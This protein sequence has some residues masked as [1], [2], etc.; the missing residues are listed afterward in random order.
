M[1]KLS[2]FDAATLTIF[3]QFLMEF[4]QHT[5]PFSHTIVY[6]QSVAPLAI[7]HLILIEFYYNYVYQL[8]RLAMDATPHS[9][10][11]FQFDYV[12]TRF[13][14]AEPQK[15]LDTVEDLIGDL[16]RF[17][18]IHIVDDMAWRVCTVLPTSLSCK[19]F[20]MVVPQLSMQFM[21][22]IPLNHG[23]GICKQRRSEDKMLRHVLTFM[24]RSGLTD[25]TKY[26]S[27][28]TLSWLFFDTQN[29][30]WGTAFGS[31]YNKYL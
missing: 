2:L 14:S 21:Y 22:D 27:N 29:N 18:T 6:T 31:P 30:I 10:Q 25:M 26:S 20:P 12:I 11:L 1:K 9:L 15:S 16:N 17:H 23:V 5:L 28:R 7:P 3:R 8:T 24:L 19:V 4:I 13:E